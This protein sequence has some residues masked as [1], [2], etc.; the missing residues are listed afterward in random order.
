[1]I[2]VWSS[3]S[4]TTFFCD[5]AEARLFT[6]WGIA[7]LRD[8]KDVTA[9]VDAGEPIRSDMAT[10]RNFIE[11]E[12][13]LDSPHPSLAWASSGQGGAEDAGEHESSRYSHYR[14][15]LALDMVITI[16]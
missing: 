14:I 1:L 15:V 6:G 16:W 10:I 7:N 12:S 3:S 5:E 2:A 9:L 11:G 4:T 13:T 8:T